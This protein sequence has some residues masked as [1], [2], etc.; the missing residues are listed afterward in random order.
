[1]GAQFWWFYDVLAVCLTA[2]I[3]YSAVV[4][5]FNK[6]V[7]QLIGTVLAFVVGFFG[8][9]WLSPGAYQIL[10]Q[11][12]IAASVQTALEDVDL[13]E[14]AASR[15]ANEIAAQVPDTVVDAQMLRDTA[16][17]VCAGQESS[18]WFVD[19]VGTVTEEIVSGKMP[20]YAAVPLAESFAENP[21]FLIAYLNYMNQ[22]DPSGA[23]AEL[24]RQFYRPEYTVMVRMVLFLILEAVIL[25]IVGIIAK[26][27]GNLE[28]LMHIRRCNRL[29]GFMVGLL[30]AA[31]ALISVAVAVKL[32]ATATNQQMLLFNEE[33]IEATK[34][35]RV[36][37]QMI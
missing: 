8:S 2:G 13:Y 1:M 31:C 27:A 34:L 6:I 9:G 15:F 30:E 35:F 24:E 16:Q 26:M 17:A 36:I 19:A 25:I 33:T 7:F 28:N 18:Q 4:K 29:L 22:N 21:E 10:Y 11:D 12:K 3:I 14:L 37:Y 5:G 23:A 32:L 20:A